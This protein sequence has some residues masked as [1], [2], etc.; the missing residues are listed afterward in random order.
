[1]IIGCSFLTQRTNHSLIICNDAQEMK[2][3]KKFKVVPRLRLIVHM[4]LCLL[5]I[6]MDMIESHLSQ[7]GVQSSYT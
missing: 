7:L 6:S 4:I 1:M 2:E 3:K 5:L